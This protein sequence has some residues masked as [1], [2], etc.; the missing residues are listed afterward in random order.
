[1]CFKQR[2][3]LRVEPGI[4]FLYKKYPGDEAIK[5]PLF[6]KK[7]SKIKNKKLEL[8]IN[9]LTLLEISLRKEKCFYRH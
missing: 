3:S 6:K 8:E 7:T 9:T 1:M 4:L 2:V 5:F